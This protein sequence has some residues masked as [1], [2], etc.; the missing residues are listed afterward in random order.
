MSC[1]LSGGDEH[2]QE[3][4]AIWLKVDCHGLCPAVNH[5]RMRHALK[6]FSFLTLLV[7]AG[8]T[9]AKACFFGCRPGEAEARAVLDHLLAQRFSPRFKIV[10][11]RITRTADFDMLVGEIR[12]YE[13][14]YKATI[15]F[16]EGAHLDCDRT[17]GSSRPEDC[18]DD[19]YFSLVRETRPVPGRQFVEAGGRRNFDE[20]FRFAEIKGQWRGPDGQP[21]DV[22]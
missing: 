8:V 7:A 6:L 13:I 15:E 22:K 18:S 10:D 9:P 2:W 16:P 17:K 21:Y 3:S 12:G 1:A 19:P 14:F 5:P 4:A 11:F 20:D